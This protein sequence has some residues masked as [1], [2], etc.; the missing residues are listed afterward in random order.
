MRIGEWSSSSSACLPMSSS[1]APS[2][3]SVD[4]QNAH[5]ATIDVAPRKRSG[6]PHDGQLAV[7]TPGSPPW[8]SRSIGL[9]TQDLRQEV[10]GALA[11]RVVEEVV[12]IVLLDDLAL[13]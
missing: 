1:L 13:V 7:L 8:F 10:L 5:T 12:R 11:L 2:R 9:V 3:T 4:L 6:P